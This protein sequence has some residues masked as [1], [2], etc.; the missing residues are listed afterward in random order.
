[1]LKP[2]G[3][4]FEAL[5]PRREQT[6]EIIDHWFAISRSSDSDDMIDVYVCMHVCHVSITNIRW[7]WWRLISFPADQG[8][9]SMKTSSGRW[10]SRRER[11]SISDQRSG[12]RNYVTAVLSRATSRLF[13]FYSLTH[14]RIIDS[15]VHMPHC[16]PFATSWRGERVQGTMK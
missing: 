15:R 2:R 4:N 10:K 3:L 8:L 11:D 16:R 12:R 5:R 7:R 1:M 9:L 14:V 13:L 6:C